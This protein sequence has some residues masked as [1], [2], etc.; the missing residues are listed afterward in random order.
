MRFDPFRELDR[1]AKQTLSVAGSVP[2]PAQEAAAAATE[3]APA[4]SRSAS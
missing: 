3:P 4:R 1:L 2:A